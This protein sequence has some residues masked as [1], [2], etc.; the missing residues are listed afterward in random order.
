MTKRITRADI[1]QFKVTSPTKIEIE[2]CDPI[3]ASFFDLQFD[4]Q[5]SGASTASARAAASSGRSVA[6]MKT[7]PETNHQ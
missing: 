5:V 3:D 2:L 1:R 7:N 4:L 6:I